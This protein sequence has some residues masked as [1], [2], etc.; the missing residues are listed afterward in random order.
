[1]ANKIIVQN[2]ENYKQ[3]KSLNI[4]SENLVGELGS[5]G[6]RYWRSISVFENISKNQALKTIFPLKVAASLLGG[7]KKG[8]VQA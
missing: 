6:E 8:V 4:L 5:G 1:M 3:T 2:F 7:W